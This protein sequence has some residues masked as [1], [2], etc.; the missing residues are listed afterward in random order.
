MQ[1]VHGCSFINYLTKELCHGENIYARIIT[2]LM[3][4]IV[5]RI[6][7]IAKISK[8]AEIFLTRRT[9]YGQENYCSISCRQIKT[10]IMYLKKFTNLGIKKLKHS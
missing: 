1:V 2:L 7:K 3:A 5:R 8:F 9:A 4:N 10:K 6:C